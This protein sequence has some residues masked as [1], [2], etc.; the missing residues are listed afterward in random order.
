MTARRCGAT[1]S[2]TV[3]RSL[4]PLRATWYSRIARQ[5][6][7]EFTIS[8]SIPG[9][10]NCD[11]ARICEWIRSRRVSLSWLL[12]T[13]RFAWT[14][15][16]I[17]LWRTGSLRGLRNIE[18]AAGNFGTRTGRWP[19]LLHLLRLPISLARG[20]IV[21]P[22]RLKPP[23]RRCVEDGASGRAGACFRSRAG[24]CP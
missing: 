3:P 10:F 22:S 23:R 6:Q 16:D 7:R 13:M 20:T 18:M 8:H 19:H 17:A 24:R 2:P 4:W 21:F 9:K 12:H 1:T 14:K 5:R 11:G 15:P